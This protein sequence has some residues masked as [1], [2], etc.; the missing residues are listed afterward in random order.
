M[1]S[2]QS[3]DQTE[4]NMPAGFALDQMLERYSTD[5]TI[6]WASKKKKSLSFSYVWNVAL[7]YYSMIHS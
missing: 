1:S 2:L 5:N 4:L 3:V 7:F 6:A